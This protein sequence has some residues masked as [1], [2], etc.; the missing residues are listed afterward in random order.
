MYC[1]RS[2]KITCLNRGR[3]ADQLF[4]RKIKTQSKLRRNLNR[5]VTY[6]GGKIHCGNKIYDETELCVHNLDT[7]GNGERNASQ[8]LPCFIEEIG[9]TI[10]M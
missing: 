7:D 5:M 6:K 8:Y 2:E 1:Y 4:K 9:T 3:L 10:D